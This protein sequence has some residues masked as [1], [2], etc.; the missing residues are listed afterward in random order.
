MY[1]SYLVEN[2]TKTFE[3][4][5]VAFGEQTVGTFYSL[6][7]VKAGWYHVEDAEYLVCPSASRTNENVDRAIEHDLE[8]GRTLFVRLLDV[9]NFI[10]DISEHVEWQPEHVSDCCQI[11]TVCFVCA[12]ISD[13]K[14][15]LHSLDLAVCDFPFWHNSAWP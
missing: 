13:K 3:L 8:N 10:W 9:G 4:L 12:R 7:E 2:A 1:A 5:K 15:P 14:H 6:S 11:G